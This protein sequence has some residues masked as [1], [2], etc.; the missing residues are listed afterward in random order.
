[1]DSFPSFD[2]PLILIQDDIIS[3]QSF[4]CYTYLWIYFTFFLIYRNIRPY[5]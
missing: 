3:L 4:S 2:G 5:E 1:M